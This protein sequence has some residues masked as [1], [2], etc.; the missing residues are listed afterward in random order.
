MT[1]RGTLNQM[2]ARGSQH[3]IRFALIWAVL[4]HV[5]AARAYARRT[6]APKPNTEERRV[7]LVMGNSNYH[8]VAALVNPSN[9]ARLVASALRSLGFTLV[10]GQAQN[11]LDKSH[12][13]RAIEDFGDRIRGAD[14]ALFYYAGHGVQVRGSNYLVPIDANPTR[15]SDVDFQL[16]DS[17]TVLHQMQ[18][19]KT[20]LNL[21]ILDACRNN[22]FDG[23]GMRAI[24]GGLAQM[25][26]PEGTLISYATQ[27][28][29]VASD[30][31][32]GDSPFTLALVHQIRQPGY[33]IFRV[34]NQIGLEVERE[35]KGE[36]QPWVSTSPIDGDFYFAGPLPS[37]VVAAVPDPDVVFWQSIERSRDAADYQAYLKEFPDGSFAPLARSRIAKYQRVTSPVGGNSTPSPM[38]STAGLSVGQQAAQNATQATPPLKLSPRKAPPSSVEQYATQASPTSQ[39]APRKAPPV[40]LAS[41]EAPESTEA[42]GAALHGDFTVVGDPLEKADANLLVKRFQRFGYNPSLI[43]SSTSPGR[44][45]LRFGP[46]SPTKAARTRNDLLQ[47]W[48]G[49]TFHLIVNSPA[50]PLMDQAAAN[51]ALESMQRLGA[52]AVLVP[53]DVNGQT[54]YQVEI[55]P[56]VT[57]D[58]AMAAGEQLGNKYSNS[59]NCPWGNCDWQYTWSGS[60]PRLLCNDPGR[61]CQPDR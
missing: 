24:G 15:E 45:S 50:G 42:I 11:D 20:R 23:R 54:K 41:A 5:F 36:Q 43:V 49:L 12:F 57:Q 7:A 3:F 61:L 37:S 16:V 32:K 25:Q 21:I 58:E 30:G 47:H 8:N 17:E 22:P 48:H 14:V 26:A 59:L 6:A 52:N 27:P 46:Y 18:D 31:D 53:H 44:Y 33:D 40:Q 13:N 1:E 39:R 2:L 55:G 51:S 35:T 29:N 38:L 4:L 10:G 28:G 34:F 19:A 56:F 9:D 60:P